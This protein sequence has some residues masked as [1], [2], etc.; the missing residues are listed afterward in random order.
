MGAAFP[1]L[2]NRLRCIPLYQK[3][4]KDRAPLKP[5]LLITP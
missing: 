5:A 4:V 1:M 2:L 3:K